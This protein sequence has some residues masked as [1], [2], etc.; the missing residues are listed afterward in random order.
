MKHKKSFEGLDLRSQGLWYSLRR[1]YVDEFHLRQVPTLPRVSLVLDLGGHKTHKRGQFDIRRYD[2][3]VIYANISTD[4]GTDVVADVADVPFKNG[5]FDAVICSEV[6]EL[7]PEPLV[8]LREIHRI[9]K[10]ERVLLICVPFLYRIQG[11]PSDY[12]RYTN[13]YWHENLV[14]IGFADIIIEKQ[15]FYWSVLMDMLRDLAYQMS[16]EGRP[17]QRLLRRLLH[18]GI[19]RACRWALKWDERLAL[20]NHKYWTPFLTTYLTKYTTGFG[21]RAL[22]RS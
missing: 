1:Y 12:G 21:I 19:A 15:G 6:L 22:K 5:C 11:D 4:K 18:T 13:Q 14:R 20:D 16:K 8:V 10:A 17:K 3:Q 2:L 9:L 7:V